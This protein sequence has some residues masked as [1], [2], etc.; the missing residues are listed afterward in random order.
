MTI[1]V[2]R[3]NRKTGRRRFT[4]KKFGDYTPSHELTQEEIKHLCEWFLTTLEKFFKKE[5][6]FCVLGVSDT[7][8]VVKALMDAVDATD[9]WYSHKEWQVDGPA[10]FQ[11]SEKRQ[12]YI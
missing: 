4:C 10:T 5:R 3:K 2:W 11:V 8:T 9:R 12:S 6:R 7:E 1:E